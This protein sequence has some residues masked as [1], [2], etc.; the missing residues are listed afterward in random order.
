MLNLPF[1]LSGA[2]Q[3]AQQL[4]I[5][6]KEAEALRDRQTGHGPEPRG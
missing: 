3:G 4:A 1:S 5:G 6:E 2:L